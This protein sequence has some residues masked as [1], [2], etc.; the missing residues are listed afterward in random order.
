MRHWEQCGLQ[1][2][3]SLRARGLNPGWLQHAT[4]S[5]QSI[6]TCDSGRHS[7]GAT[8]SQTGLTSR[9]IT[10]ARAWR[11]GV[12]APSSTPSAPYDGRQSA[13]GRGG[14]GG[15][16]PH[17][18]LSCSIH[19][20]LA[21]H[22]RSGAGVCW[23]GRGGRGTGMAP[24]L[25]ARHDITLHVKTINMRRLRVRGWSMKQNCPATVITKRAKRA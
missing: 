7:P 22:S 6:C 5:Y 24:E 9:P 20:G 25:T 13:V 12:P 18:H 2:F 23:R 14:R 1:K 8:P 19:H 11:L 3:N 21:E 17:H 16:E 10:G 4:L 15:E